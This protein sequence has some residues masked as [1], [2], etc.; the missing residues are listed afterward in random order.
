MNPFQQAQ[1]LAQT[2]T[3]VTQLEA[4]VARMTHD[5]NAGQTVTLELTEGGRTLALAISLTDVRQLAAPAAAPATLRAVTLADNDLLSAMLTSHFRFDLI[6]A[7][8]HLGPA[9]VGSKIKKSPEQPAASTP[10]PLSAAAPGAP[11]IPTEPD[12][13]WLNDGRNWMLSQ[14]CRY[15]T[16]AGITLTAK[17]G[18]KTDLASIPRLF[19]AFLAPQELSVTAPTMHDLLY[20]SGGAVALPDG[21]VLP[22]GQTF[23]RPAADALFLELMTLFGIAKWKRQTAYR[24]V[25]FFGAPAW[26]A[27]AD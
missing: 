26:R 21:E 13:K 6:E 14:D 17:T 7:A 22:A 12:I 9:Y 27:R 8:R 19:W 23:T 5:I 20:R 2:S 18:F 16:D 15:R 24:A 1:V 25:G 4:Q 10:R 3:Y 11:L